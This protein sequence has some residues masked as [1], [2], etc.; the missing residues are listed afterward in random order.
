MVPNPYLL[1]M[2]LRQ[3]AYGLLIL[4]I[5]MSIS[6]IHCLFLLILVYFTHIFKAGD[7][8]PYSKH[9]NISRVFLYVCSFT[10]VP[11]CKVKYRTLHLHNLK[12][13]ICNLSNVKYP[14]FHCVKSNISYFIYIKC[15]IP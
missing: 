12:Y 4:C 8:F 13:S 2:Y 11:L 9:W 5:Y 10:Y 3:K 6:N 1:H 14:I 7:D 15:T